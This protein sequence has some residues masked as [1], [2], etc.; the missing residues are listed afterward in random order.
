V[1]PAAVAQF[2]RPWNSTHTRHCTFAPAVD[3]MNSS[4]AAAS[5]AASAYSV[6]R[7]SLPP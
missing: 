5:T 7:F 3:M 6:D 1:A 2:G 4:A